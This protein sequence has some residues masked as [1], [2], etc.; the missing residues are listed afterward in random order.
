MSS[1]KKQYTVSE[2]QKQLR[3]C[4]YVYYTKNKHEIWKTEEQDRIDNRCESYALTT[5]HNPLKIGTMKGLIT[6]LGFKNFEEC[7]SF[8]LENK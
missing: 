4:G 5:T 2:A 1:I 3:L 8:W 7:H 6:F